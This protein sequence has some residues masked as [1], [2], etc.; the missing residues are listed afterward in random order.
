VLDTV[1]RLLE[2]HG[3]GFSIDDVALEAQVHKTTVYRKWATKPMLVAAALDRLAERTIDLEP[4]DDPV[5]DLYELT[6]R[7]ARALATKAGG[8]TLRA[9]IAAA[10]DDPEL[11]ATTRRFMTRRYGTAVAIIEAGQRTGVLRDDLDPQILWTC[12][13]NPLHMRAM[14]GDPA[15]EAAAVTVVEHVL[16]GAHPVTS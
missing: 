9:V 2:D 16:G 12:I 10:A 6:R 15:D 3:Y 13:V 7:V 1:C 14:L 4:S 11:S 8:N 5:A